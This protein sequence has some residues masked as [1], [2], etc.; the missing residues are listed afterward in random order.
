MTLLC[1][2][3]SII[4]DLKQPEVDDDNV[5]NNVD[6]DDN[7]VD[8]ENNDDNVDNNDNDDKKFRRVT[9]EKKK[10]QIG[11]EVEK[12]TEEIFKRNIS[13]GFV[14]QGID[15]M[16]ICKLVITFIYLP[17]QVLFIQLEPDPFE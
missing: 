6:N 3:F 2:L 14:R 4:S 16:N 5:E 8:I 7:N 11:K 9:S 12:T 10:S 13:S 1:S 17:L 15:P